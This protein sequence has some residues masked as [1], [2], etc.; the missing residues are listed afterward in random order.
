MILPLR[1]YSVTLPRSISATI[2]KPSYLSSNTHPGP[3]NG[4]SV[5]VASIGRKCFGSVDAR[6]IRNP[7]RVYAPYVDASKGENARRMCDVPV[8]ARGPT[9]RA[10]HPGVV[11]DLRLISANQRGVCLDLRSLS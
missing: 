3:S 4:A 6:L 1:L 11:T 9:M 8:R 2:R 10:P 5:N 7:S